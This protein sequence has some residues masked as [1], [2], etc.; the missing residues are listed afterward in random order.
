MN[1]KT[2]QRLAILGVIMVSLA[3]LAKFTVVGEYLSYKQLSHTLVE[4]GSIGIIIFLAAFVAG[5]LM[6]LPAFLFTVLA[7]LV[8]GIGWGY[9]I[10]FLGSFI[11]AFVHFQV[12]RSIGG[13][14]LSEIKIPLMQKVMAKFD[15][16][17][18]TTV[19]I[20]RL[21]FFISPPVNYLL[22]LSN[23]RTR[24][25]VLGTLVGNILPLGLHAGLLYFTREWV[26]RTIS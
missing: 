5:A 22:A 20:L 26:L 25:F 21:L 17:P 24:D 1:R 11:A 7:F 3:L 9:A 8:Y 4:S 6:N 2:I 19:I 10:A 12:V 15:Q 16:R 14:A 23:V 13:Q 18:L